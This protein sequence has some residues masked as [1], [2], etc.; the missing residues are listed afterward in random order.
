M[1]KQDIERK[2]EEKI[3]SEIQQ[4]KQK[5]IAVFETKLKDAKQRL[6]LLSITISQ[7]QEELSV[8][9]Q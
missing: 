2:T 1:A 9:T 3:E 6:Q 7:K 8:W 5:E 4:R